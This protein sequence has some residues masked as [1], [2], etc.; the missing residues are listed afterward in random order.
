MVDGGA[1][2]DGLL[3]CRHGPGAIGVATF[4]AS[5][6]MPGTNEEAEHIATQRQVKLVNNML[7]RP[8]IVGPARLQGTGPMQS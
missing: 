6:K 2:T 8:Q 7:F 3:L 4:P 5:E 1:E